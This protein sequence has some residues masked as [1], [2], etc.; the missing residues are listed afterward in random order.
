MPDEADEHR[1]DRFTELL[2]RIVTPADMAVVLFFGT[3]GFVVDAA[4]NSI[5]FLEP[6][7]VGVTAATGALAVKQ[8]A[9]SVYTRW[10]APRRKRRRLEELEERAEAFLSVLKEEQHDGLMDSLER[11]SRLFRRG[12]IDEEDFRKRFKELVEEYRSR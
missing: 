6:G 8:G 12:I 4:L 11:E 1:S 10:R 5:G 2:D 3:S 7:Y 9:V